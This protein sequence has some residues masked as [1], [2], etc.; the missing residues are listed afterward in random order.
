MFANSA[1]VVFGALRVKVA[2]FAVF[3]N[4]K[5]FSQINMPEHASEIS[6]ENA[7]KVD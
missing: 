7:T 3:E 6:I 2:I 5:V 4:L 1:I